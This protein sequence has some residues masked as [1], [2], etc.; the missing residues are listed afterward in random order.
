MRTLAATSMGAVHRNLLAL[1]SAAAVILA[2]PVPL[3][4]AFEFRS[5]FAA[6]ARYEGPG[7]LWLVVMWVGA[8]AL[9]GAIL[10]AVAVVTAFRKPGSRLLAILV[11][12][13]NLLLLFAQV[14]N[15]GIFG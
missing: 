15:T 5:Q 3:I 12:V 8:W 11:L 6:W 13:L 10:G 7:M 2:V 4:L 1:L 9:L 14:R